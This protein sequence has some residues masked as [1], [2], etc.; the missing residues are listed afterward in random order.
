[1]RLKHVLWEP[2]YR[3]R[4]SDSESHHGS[5]AM[6]EEAGGVVLVFHVQEYLTELHTDLQE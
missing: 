3:Y 5:L 1:M 2:S 6:K 4:V